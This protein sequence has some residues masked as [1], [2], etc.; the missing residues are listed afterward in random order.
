MHVVT[1]VEVSAVTRAQLGAAIRDID[2]LLADF[3][4]NLHRCLVL[5]RPRALQVELLPGDLAL[6]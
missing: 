1:V 2:A 5:V 3:L 6:T 4:N